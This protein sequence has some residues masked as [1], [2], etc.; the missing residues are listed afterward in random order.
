MEA[1]AGRIF[2]TFFQEVDSTIIE[3]L[4][5]TVRVASIPPAVQGCNVFS[6]MSVAVCYRPLNDLLGSFSAVASLESVIIAGQIAEIVCIT[7]GSGCSFFSVR[8]LPYGPI[9]F[10]KTRALELT[11]SRK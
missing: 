11:A 9:K 8:C 5:D 6:L 1:C 4:N 7:G 2:E 3:S 10:Q